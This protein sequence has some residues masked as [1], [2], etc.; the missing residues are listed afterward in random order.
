MQ[1]RFSVSYGGFGRR[2]RQVR[3]AE[4]ETVHQARRTGLPFADRI[5]AHYSE[6]VVFSSPL[7]RTIG[8]D[9][10]DTIRGRVALRSYFSAALRRF[11]SSCFGLRAVYA[12]DE[13]VIL[14]CDSVNGLVAC[15]KLKLNEKGQITGVGVL[16]QSE[17]EQCRTGRISFMRKAQPQTKMCC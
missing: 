14:L 10:S 5:L 7:V 3:H 4:A 6:D 15:E 2:G 16:R 1:E 13:D 9:N 11:P 8:G 17:T 12:D